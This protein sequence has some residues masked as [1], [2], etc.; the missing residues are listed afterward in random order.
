M[1]KF[2]GILMVLFVLGFCSN[3][4]AL[5]LAGKFGFA[6]KGG[7]GIP[8]GDFADDEGVGADMGFGFGVTGEY[9]LSNQ[10]ALGG[11][12]DYSSFGLGSYG[13]VDVSFKLTSFGG[14]VKYIFPTN[15]NIAP[16]LKASAGKYQPKLSA[17]SGGGSASEPLDM[18]FGFGVGAGVMLKASD[19]VLIGGEAAF[20]GIVSQETEEHGCDL[21]YIQI[22]AGVTF[23]VGGK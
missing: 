8:M 6:G 13:D 22:N 3:V 18:R 16:Y 15:T 2:F 17:S 11:Y 1:K 12:F 21:Q 5:D 14:S 7:I 9:F 20:H 4:L 10:V 23:L 19:F